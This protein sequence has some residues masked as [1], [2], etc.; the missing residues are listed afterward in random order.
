MAI[1]RTGLNFAGET[2]STSLSLSKHLRVA[3]LKRNSVHGETGIICRSDSILYFVE[4]EHL[5]GVPA[6]RGVIF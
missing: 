5:I 4:F 6:I 3:P 2:S 1:L